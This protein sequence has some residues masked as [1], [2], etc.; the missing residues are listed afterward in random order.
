MKE[1]R[2]GST[3]KV[4]RVIKELTKAGELYPEYAAAWTLLGRTKI[5]IADVSSAEQALQRAL[6]IDPLYIKPYES[7]IVLRRNQGDRNSADE[8]ADVTLGFNSVDVRMRW[9]M[10]VSQYELSSFDEAL[11]MIDAIQN[12]EQEAVL[13]PQTH[14]IRDLIHARRGEFDEALSSTVAIWR[15]HPSR[16]RVTGSDENSTS[17][18]ISASSSPR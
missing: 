8:L 1:I 5:Q 10:A 15:L 2:K 16:W 11:G 17:G 12:D 3:A 18:R 7:L 4:D 9:F 14:H 13:Y 6:E